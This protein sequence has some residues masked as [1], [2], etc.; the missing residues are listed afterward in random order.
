MVYIPNFTWTVADGDYLQRMARAGFTVDQIASAMRR[1]PIDVDRFCREN[2][3][4]VRTK[5]KVR[6]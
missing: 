3:V 2:H 1:K 4:F 6:A 5:P